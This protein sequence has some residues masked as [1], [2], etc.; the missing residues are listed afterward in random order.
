MIGGFARCAEGWR[1]ILATQRERFTLVL[2]GAVE[3]QPTKIVGP[4]VCQSYQSAR[5]SGRL[6]LPFSGLQRSDW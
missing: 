3:R 6:L 2:T 5:V 1:L 4:Q